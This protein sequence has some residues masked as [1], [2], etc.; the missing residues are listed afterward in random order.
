MSQTVKLAFS[1]LWGILG[2]HGSFL[3]LLIIAF[4]LF[5]EQIVNDD[6][7]PTCPCSWPIGYGTIMFLF[8]SLITFLVA[9]F[10]YFR[11]DNNNVPWRAVRKLYEFKCA[12]NFFD[13]RSDWDIHA[14]HCIRCQLRRRDWN[15]VKIAL[16]AI[17][18]ML[19][20]LVW[21][22][23]S[24]LQAYYYVCAHV[25]P[26]QNT[27]IN[28]CGLPAEL[29]PDD[30]E[31]DYFLAVIRSKVIGGV[32]FVSTLLV[33]GVFVIVYGEIKNYLKKV[34]LSQSRSNGRPSNLQVH[35]SV[36][37]G[38]SSGTSESASFHGN[39]DSPLAASESGGQPT[40]QDQQQVHDGNKAIRINLSD[41]FTTALKGCLQDSAWQGIDI[42]CSQKE[43][44]T[45]LQGSHTQYPVG[46]LHQRVNTADRTYDAVYEETSP[47]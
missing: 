36:L 23:L 13:G 34:D 28:Y 25:G 32:L 45:S 8:P 7:G 18:S 20:P 1:T 31:K 43:E 5:L 21:L 24:F 3:L 42:R 37:P 47:P 39:R 17:F 27:L 41:E 16:S 6:L 33:L 46:S 29:V 4:K 26:I 30:Y 10:A 22:S 40:N 9:F 2:W 12:C 15:L 11:Q 44:T 19:Y 35:V 38:R 14:Q